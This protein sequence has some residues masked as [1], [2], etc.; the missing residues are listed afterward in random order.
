M[1]NAHNKI[2]KFVF[3][4]LF[5]HILVRSCELKQSIF[6]LIKIYKKEIFESVLI[7]KQI[8]LL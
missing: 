5:M 4:N 7:I 6:Y 2:N 8:F 3:L 1:V